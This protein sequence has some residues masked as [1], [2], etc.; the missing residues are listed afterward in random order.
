[1]NPAYQKAFDAYD[2]CIDTIRFLADTANRVLRSRNSSER[3]D[4][5]TILFNFDAILQY[6]LMQVAVNDYEFSVQEARFLKDLAQYCDFCDYLESISDKL[7][8]W[9]LFLNCNASAI[10]ELLELDSICEDIRDKAEALSALFAM[11]D[12]VTPD[13][14]YYESFKNDFFKIYYY[15]FWI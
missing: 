1:M 3:I 11:I 4:D 6:S 2:R 13:T 12:A 8:N 10:K 5:D 7:V 14:D 15:V 9:D